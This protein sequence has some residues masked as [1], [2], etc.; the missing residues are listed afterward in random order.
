ML[1]LGQLSFSLRHIFQFQIRHAP[2]GLVK[3]ISSI[4]GNTYDPLDLPKG[5]NHLA[6]APCY[7]GKE[8]Y[9]FD[10]IAIFCFFADCHAPGNPG[11]VIDADDG[12]A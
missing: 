2:G 9:D 7:L 8:N 4:N 10:N 6:D 11:R 12:S 1:S 5:L 3:A